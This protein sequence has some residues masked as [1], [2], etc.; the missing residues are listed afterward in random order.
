MSVR[1]LAITV[2]CVSAAGSW[3]QTPPQ[4]NHNVN[5]AG[6]IDGE[7]HPELIPD[8]TAYRLYM[9]TISTLPNAAAEDFARQKSHIAALQLGD[10]DRI[11][12]I[13]ILTD[14]RV[15]YAALIDQYNESATAALAQGTAPDTKLFLQK[16][17]DL[18]QSVMATLRQ[19]LS[20]EGMKK[21]DSY[22]Q[23]QKR[24]MKVDAAEAQ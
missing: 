5:T 14:F 1:L 20:T 24:T 23:S 9:F 15:R 12:L 10:A 2:L 19:S 3:A 11:A 21:L 17:N 18:V 16:R 22:I 7:S 8:A 13:G 6:M 4:H